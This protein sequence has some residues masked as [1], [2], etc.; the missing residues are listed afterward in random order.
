M[1]SE[2]SAVGR[3]LQGSRRRSSPNS[4]GSRILAAR[5]LCPAKHRANRQFE[6]RRNEQVESDPDEQIQKSRAHG[7]RGSFVSR[8]RCVRCSRNR[9]CCNLSYPRWGI[10][11]LCGR[12]RRRHVYWL[13]RHQRSGRREPGY[14]DYRFPKSLLGR[15]RNSLQRC[16]RDRSAVGHARGIWHARPELRSNLRGGGPHG[17]FSQRRGPGRLLLNE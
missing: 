15:R 3:L 6:Q 12:R 5:F 14:L 11:L 8:R 13:E 17:H 7:A 4:N 16:W 10:G 1:P 9:Q 2:H